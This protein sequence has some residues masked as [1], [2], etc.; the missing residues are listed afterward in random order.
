MAQFKHPFGN[1]E[2]VVHIGDMTCENRTDRISLY[3]SCDITRDQQGL[4]QALQLYSL[5][6][7]VIASLEGQQ[8]PEHISIEQPVKMNSPL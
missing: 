6:Q 5:L 7:G 1:E 4:E 8:L 2:E 3:G